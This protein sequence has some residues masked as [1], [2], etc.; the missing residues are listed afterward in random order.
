MNH[1]SIDWKFWAIF[2]GTLFLLSV[3][4]GFISTESR[5]SSLRSSLNASFDQEREQWEDAKEEYGERQ[6]KLG[7]DT[8]TDDLENLAEISYGIGFENGYR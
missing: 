7:Y 1:R 6:Y 4:S 3:L 5:L 2:Q 8:A